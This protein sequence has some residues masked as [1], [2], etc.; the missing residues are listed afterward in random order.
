M[1]NRGHRPDTVTEGHQTDSQ[2]VEEALR[3]GEAQSG[4]GS[5]VSSQLQGGDNPAGGS[6]GFGNFDPDSLTTGDECVFDAPQVINE[7]VE[8]HFRSLL[9]KDV[10]EAMNKAHP[11]PNTPV[12]K[13]P[14][15]DGFVH[16]HLQS[17][18]P[19]ASE[20]QLR[21]IQSVLLQAS[22]PLTCL[23]ADL[24]TNDMLSEG[25]TITVQ[26]ALD[27]VQRMLVLMGN[28]NVL[29]T[30]ARRNGILQSVDK[31]LVKY[32]S[33]CAAPSGEYLF[34]KDFASSLKQEVENDKSLSKVVSLVQRHHPYNKPRQFTLG[35]SKKQFFPKGPVG[36][37]G[38][39]QGHYT[40]PNKFVPRKQAYNPK[41]SPFQSTSGRS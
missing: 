19:K 29:L 1:V 34:G 30:E 6:S 14:K 32:G 7:Y 9:K 36:K 3:D 40:T 41:P 35:H 11:V 24:I 37:P 23:W 5:S 20:N 25:S 28:A 21:T 27:V 16:N 18:F 38:S 15:V 13:A 33:D 2:F 39:Q 8:K 22:G 12:M 10:R 31:S 26:D 17:R 4:D